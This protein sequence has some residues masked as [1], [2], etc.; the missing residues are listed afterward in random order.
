MSDHYFGLFDGPVGPRLT[1]LADTIAS[2]RYARLVTYDDPAT[3]PRGWFAAQSHGHP[4]DQMIATA[5]MADLSA[6]GIEIRDRR[7]VGPDS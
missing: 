6:A 1:E 4:Y 3:G 2:Q 7:L 5:V